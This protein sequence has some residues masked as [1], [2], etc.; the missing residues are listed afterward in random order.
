MNGL[1]EFFTSLLSPFR[2]NGQM[3]LAQIQIVPKP[4]SGYN[5]VQKEYCQTGTRMM[6]QTV[7]RNTLKGNKNKIGIEHSA[8]K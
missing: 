6:G 2:S 3:H 7:L 8:T 4:S 1:I 5:L